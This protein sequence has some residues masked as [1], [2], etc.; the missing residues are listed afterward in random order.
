MSD[1]CLAQQG[2]KLDNTSTR[3]LPVFPLPIFLLSGGMQRLRIFEPKYLKM[4]SQATQNDGFIIGFFKKDNPF[5]VA[6]WGTHVKIVNFDMGEDGVLTIDVLAESMVKF[7][8]IDTQRDGLVIAESEPLA[9]W[10]SDQDT[11][12]I[13]DDDVVG[14]SDT[15]KSVFDTHNE[16]SA[17][18]QTRYLRYSKWVCARLLEIIPLSLEEKE[19]FIQDISFAQLKELL[20]SMCEKNQKKSDPITSS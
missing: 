18:Y 5:S 8:N 2:T 20:S 6:E 1:S 3:W 12:S 11:T 9:H 14:L 13:E 15:L 17:L 16:F 19:M 7:V 4:V 10:S